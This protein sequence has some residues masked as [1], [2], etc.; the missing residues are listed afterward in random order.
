MANKREGQNTVSPYLVVN[1]ARKQIEFL[2]NVFG[3]VETF[4]S[5]RPDGAIMHAEV[6]IGDSK[7]MIGDANDNAKPRRA[8][9]YVYV[10]DV[11]AV[12]QRGL[13]AGA[14]S[15]SAPEDKPYGERNAGFEDA[16]G[17]YWWVGRPTQG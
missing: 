2:E 13:D 7:V 10:N 8:T 14:Q 11:D 1:G 9:C 4:C 12:Y 15:L 5:A 6:R 3:G 16:W 17:N